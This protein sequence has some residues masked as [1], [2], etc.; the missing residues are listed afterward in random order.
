[1]GQFLKKKKKKKNYSN[2]SNQK[3]TLKK[4]RAM[5]SKSV[6]RS[7]NKR[8]ICLVR[9]NLL[10]MEFTKNQKNEIIL[11]SSNWATN[12]FDIVI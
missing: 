2:S 1:M 5:N 8:I 12:F 6:Q 7:S 11:A 4:H 3:L 10:K 9:V